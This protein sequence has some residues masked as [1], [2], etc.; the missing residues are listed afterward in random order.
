M[1][2]EKIAKISV[3]SR[4]AVSVA[5][6]GLVAMLAYIWAVE[7]QMNYLNAAQQY[8]DMITAVEKKTKTI[9]FD[10]KVKNQ[11]MDTMTT[12]VI[13]LEKKFFDNQTARDF[14]GSIEKV[15]SNNNC[16]IIGL[17]ALNEKSSDSYNTQKNPGNINVQTYLLTF[18]AN[19]SDVMNFLDAIDNYDQKVFIDE[20]VMN[21]V[22]G[23]DALLCKI[24]C[25]I[26]V[27]DKESADDE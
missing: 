24:K 16:R 4:T 1:L 18:S 6:V 7:P 13:S 27:V 25:S 11:Q 12:Q 26:C 10:I 3:Y 2:I 19:F 22:A 23:S 5:I 9:E 14:F 8:Q 15:M 20:L 17:N 21:T